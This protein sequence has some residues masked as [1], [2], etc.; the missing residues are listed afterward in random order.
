MVGYTATIEGRWRCILNRDMP[1]L[2]HLE[3]GLARDMPMASSLQ[4]TMCAST[5]DTVLQKWISNSF[6]VA[7]TL[8]CQVLLCGRTFLRQSDNIVFDNI[9]RLDLQYGGA[10]FR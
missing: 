4:K 8:A 7:M 1:I 6:S 3:Q 2:V 10:C 9:P 5:C